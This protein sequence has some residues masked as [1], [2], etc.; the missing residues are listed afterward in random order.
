MT[1]TN[2]AAPQA[3]ETELQNK[4]Q[5]LLW[6]LLSACFG[7]GEKAQNLESLSKE[8]TKDL[9]MPELVLDPLVSITTLLQRFPDLKSDFE[10]PCVTLKMFFRSEQMKALHVVN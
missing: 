10:R 5:A 3:A 8:I 2:S 6:R 1:D 9:G 4:Q 7:Q